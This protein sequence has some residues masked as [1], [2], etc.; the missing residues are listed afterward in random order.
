MLSIYHVSIIVGGCCWCY[1]RGMSGRKSF[2]N[3]WNKQEILQLAIP[4]VLS[5]LLA[6]AP[7]FDKAYNFNGVTC[8]I[9]KNKWECAADECERGTYTDYFL[10]MN[11]LSLVLCF[12]IIVVSMIILFRFVLKSEKKMDV[13]TRHSKR[14]RDGRQGDG[15]QAAGGQG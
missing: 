15:K 14:K 5:L 1:H 11:G 10:L 4:L 6:I 8:H 9:A 2:Y 3:I 12:V 7:F 13:Y